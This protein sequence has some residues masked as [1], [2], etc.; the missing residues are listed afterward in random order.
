MGY[1]EDLIMFEKFESAR[2]KKFEKGRRD[3]EHEQ[4]W[5]IQ[6]IDPYGE[7][8]DELLDIYNY[9]TLVKNS[10]LV[11]ELRRLSVLM[12]IAIDKERNSRYNILK[13]EDID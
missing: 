8:L 5:S 3:H 10:K 9:T 11:D 1:T 2:Q 13:E 12:W 6:G 7:I 4:D